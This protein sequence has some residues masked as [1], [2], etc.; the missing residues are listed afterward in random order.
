MLG[1]QDLQRLFA[2]AIDPAKNYFVFTAHESDAMVGML[3]LTFGE[4]SYQARPFAYGDDLF[5]DENQRGRGVAKRLVQEAATL[6]RERGCSCIM[7][8]VGEDEEG[9]QAFYKRNGF[10]N[11]KNTLYSLPLA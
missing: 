1:L 11:L 2:K 7:L 8:G 9:A 10:I 4:S 5:V 3:S 6:A